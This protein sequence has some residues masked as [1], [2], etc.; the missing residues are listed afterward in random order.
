MK[1]LTMRHEATRYFTLGRRD[2]CVAALAWAR[3]AT[4]EEIARVHAI[5]A[6]AAAWGVTWPWQE[7]VEE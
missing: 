3:T 1:P 4:P 6:Q 5:A 2:G 7:A